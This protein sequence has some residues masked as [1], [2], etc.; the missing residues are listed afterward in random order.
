MGLRC[1][2]CDFIFAADTL[3]RLDSGELVCVSC[4]DEAVTEWQGE[5]EL[6]GRGLRKDDGRAQAVRPGP[7]N[8]GIDL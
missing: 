6:C 4:A 3:V 2:R 5:C 8:N 1:D 7:D